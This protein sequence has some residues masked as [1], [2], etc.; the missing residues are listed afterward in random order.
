VEL[1]LGSS[2]CR[3]DFGVTFWQRQEAPTDDRKRRHDF[4]KRCGRV[5]RWKCRFNRLL[6]YQKFGE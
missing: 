2:E 5:P 4:S 6:E 3:N 1:G